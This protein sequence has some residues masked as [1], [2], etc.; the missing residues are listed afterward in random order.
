LRKISSGCERGVRENVV[1][2]KSTK[3]IIEGN[4]TCRLHYRSQE[5]YKEDSSCRHR[6][7]SFKNRFLGDIP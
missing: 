4:V 1:K 5:D 3:I 2:P 7:H 6:S